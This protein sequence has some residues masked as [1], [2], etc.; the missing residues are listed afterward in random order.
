MYKMTCDSK[1][2][3]LTVNPANLTRFSNLFTLSI[4]DEGYSSLFTLSVPDE[5]YSRNVS[6]LGLKSFDFERT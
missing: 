5:G 4:P 3:L 6:Y 2:N 1:I